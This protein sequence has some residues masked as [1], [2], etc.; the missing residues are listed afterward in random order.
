MRAEKLYMEGRLEAPGIKFYPSH[1]NYYLLETVHAEALR[2]GLLKKGIVVRGCSDFRGLGRRHLRVA[3]R[4]RAENMR[5][6]DEMERILKDG[7]L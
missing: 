7:S 6:L 3:V 1:A 2:A 5:L 4:S